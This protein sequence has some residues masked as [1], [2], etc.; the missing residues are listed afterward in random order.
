MPFT[1]ITSNRLEIL[2]EKLAE[3]LSQPLSS[4]L[5][6]EIIVVQS[7]GMERWLSLQ[8]A[9]KLGV[10]ANVRF[11]FPNHFLAEIGERI[12]VAALN[13]DS[14]PYSKEIL[15]WRIMRI[16]PQCLEQPEFA[17]P[18]RYLVH[19]SGSAQ[20][21]NGT[22]DLKRIQLSSRI[23]D[24]FDQYL[25][26]RPDMISNWERGSDG[27]SNDERWQA[28]LWRRLT[29]ECEQPHRAEIGKQIIATLKQSS[30]GEFDLPQRVSVF[31]VSTLPPFHLAV[32]D[33]L[34]AHSEVN[35]FLMN[36]CKEYWGE[37]RSRR[38]IGR[39]QR[40]SLSTRSESS[41]L[42]LNFAAK[43]FE[44]GNR[45]LASMGEQGRDFFDLILE[46]FDAE[47][48]D[49]S[50]DPSA[51]SCLTALQ[52]DILNLEEPDTP[53]NPPSRGDLKDRSVQIH[54]CHSERREIEVLLDHLLALFES[55]P[56][57]QPRD[58]V[59]MAPDIE[60]YSP[61]IQSVFDLPEDDPRRLPYSISDRS[62]SA[63]GEM[64]SMF[65]TLLGLSKSRLT[66]NEVLN[67][68]GMSIVSQRYGL[69]EDEL[70]LI[71]HWVRKTRIRWGADADYRKKLGLPGFQQNTWRAGLERLL[72]GYALPG[73]QRILYGDGIVPYDDIEGD[74]ADVLGKLLEFTNH[75]F[76][77]VAQLER[78]RP[79]HDWQEFLLWVLDT[80]F[81]AR[82]KRRAPQR[83]VALS[84][85]AQRTL[86]LIRRVV[87]SLKELQ[88]D[89]QFEEEIDIR[90]ILY[91]INSQFRERG[92]G[93]GY[94]GGGVTFCS[95]LPMR[96]I[97]FKVV[98]LIGMNSDAYPRS[99]PQL[100]FDLMQRAPRKG[101]RSRRADDRYLFL[102]SLLSAR[103]VFY[104]SYIGQSIKDN[105]EIPPSVVV[106]ELLDYL[107]H[108]FGLSEKECRQRFVTS[109]P[110]QGFSRKYFLGEN[111]GGLFTYSQENLAI[112]RSFLK[113]RIAGPP[114]GGVGKPFIAA[115]LPQPEEELRTVSVADLY[116]FFR[117]PVRYL[118]N[119]RLGIFVS[120]EA[121]LLED[122]EPF[123]LEDLER[124]DVAQRLKRALLE[125]LDRR[126]FKEIE[127]RLGA[128][129][130]GI[131]GDHQYISLEEKVDEFVQR[132]SRFVKTVAPRPLAVDLPIGDFHLTGRLELLTEQGIVLYE[133]ASADAKRALRVWI[134]HLVH[135]A[136][137]SDFAKESFLFAVNTSTKGE[138]VGCR[139]RPLSNSREILHQL[140]NV[141]W[142]GLTE[143]LRFFPRSSWKFVSLIRQPEKKKSAEQNRKEALQT[144]KK[145][146][147]DDYRFPEKKDPYWQICFGR[148]D[149]AL[150]EDFCQLAEEIL[151]PLF[152]HREELE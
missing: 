12:G 101:D 29:A 19:Q 89:A 52:R 121:A 115:P 108:R 118:F 1:L 82:G 23:A 144:A 78:P 72:L 17:A 37:I 111:G 28:E 147:W 99:S 39:A 7:K 135:N 34:A 126:Q 98:C 63:E 13:G 81:D 11:P 151:G 97:P 73:E 87:L 88:L 4:P 14:D 104:V 43:Y 2:A 56:D 55:H 36:P 6:P 119:K 47:I 46:N 24:L 124:Y 16:L 27:N 129:P 49:E 127:E 96:S 45:L 74:Q 102:E 105:S 15:T 93:F 44:D 69:S 131:L 141:Y 32:L 53:L 8:L 91:Y 59:V 85:D 66:A 51:D 136:I 31:G 20:P 40:R 152:E 22:S 132:T 50:F 33:A 67:I 57:L 145:N 100:G 107:A 110:L 117:H 71:Q 92:Y 130:H 35:L 21:K 18:Q 77:L 114:A 3:I 128:L 137:D 75:L 109:H 103:A 76:H 134:E 146:E 42:A 64:V 142:R 80:F 83:C 54:S 140:L 116:R 30:P 149:D 94:L 61:F 125:K 123:K 79:L 9:E 113:E 41:Q 58:V 112:A 138:W 48:I 25:V 95:M 139:F 68:L 148:E 5:Q 106:V 86:Y 84:S 90:A 62:F 10:C 133:Y 60:K 26:F 120:D 143:P 38:E 150:T 70:Q 65:L 122:D